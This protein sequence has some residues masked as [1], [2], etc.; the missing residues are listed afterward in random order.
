LTHRAQRVS[1]YFS[2]ARALA[3]TT[4]Q[5]V[6]RG[7]TDRL[8]STSNRPG[9]T[10]DVLE[11]GRGQFA[12]LAYVSSNSAREIHVLRL[13]NAFDRA[14]VGQSL[15]YVLN[16]LALMR[17]VQELKGGYWA[18]TPPRLV[19]LAQ[20]AILIA[21]IPTDELKRHFAGVQAAGYA[22]VILQSADVDLPKQ[23]L[24]DWAGFDVID[25][26]VWAG[27]ALR[28]AAKEMSPTI[29]PQNIE[30]FGVQRILGPFGRRAAPGWVTDT[31]LVA[32]VDGKTVLCRSR[33]A[34]NYYRY[35]WGTLERGRIVAESVAPKEI[36]RLQYGIAALTDRPITVV[37]DRDDGRRVVRTFAILPRPERRFLLGLA[38]RCNARAGKAHQFQTEEHMQLIAGALQKLGCE[39]RSAHA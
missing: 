13:R 35:F 25:T 39:I 8:A 32:S 7:Q 17:E 23:A 15:R 3:V 1:S 26:K 29:E 5:E 21:P 18:P 30:F 28:K 34:E 11:Y 20:S 9:G 36:D 38:E 37:F 4:Q 16:V 24:D 22:R 14:G 33:L 12:A 27:N 19:P 6:S 2:R 31:R 10:R